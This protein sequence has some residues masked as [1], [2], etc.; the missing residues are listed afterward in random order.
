MYCE[1]RK[2]GFLRI[3]SFLEFVVPYYILVLH[4]IGD[5]VS[6]WCHAFC[7][8]PLLP[9]HILGIASLPANAPLSFSCLGTLPYDFND[10]VALEWPLLL[11]SFLLGTQTRPLSRSRTS[12]HARR[13]QARGELYLLMKISQTITGTT[14]AGLNPNTS[15][16]QTKSLPPNTPLSP[17]YRET[18]WNNLGESQICQS[19]LLFSINFA[20]TSVPILTYTYTFQLLSWHRYSPILPDIFNH[21]T[22]LSHL[23]PPRRREYHSHQ[24]RI[25]GCQAAPVG[26]Q[27]QSQS[28]PCLEWK[29]LG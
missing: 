5:D 8:R 22:R 2:I 13:L 27:S 23:S 7:Q 3:P 19:L 24:G 6:Y 29:R 21:F 11:P 1:N 25:W 18:C 20:V 12:F 16:P 9:F 28:G 10:F 26:L 17:S 14:R 4:K 15:I